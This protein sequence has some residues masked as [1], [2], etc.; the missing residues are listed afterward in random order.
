MSRGRVFGRVALGVLVAALI[1]SFLSPTFG[2]NVESIPTLLGFFLGLAVTLVVFE[3][4]GLVLR[5][6]STGEWGRLKVLPWTLLVAALFVLV[7]RLANLQPGYLYGLVLGTDYEREPRPGDEARE[8]IAGMVAT[9]LL[10]IGAW[11]V[12]DGVRAGAFAAG[13]AVSTIA[14]TATAAI[15]VNGLEAAAFG[16]LPL[17]FMPGRA[18]YEWNRRAWAVLFAASVFTFVQLLIGPTSG[19]L[20]DL[21]LQGW[22]AAIGVFAAFGAFSIGF[23]AWFRFRPAPAAAAPGT[24][25]AE[26]S[27]ATAGPAVA[28]A[29][30]PVATADAAPAEP[31]VARAEPAAAD[32]GTPPAEPEA[33]PASA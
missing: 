17:R 32:P 21:D 8:T 1:S 25:T 5:H 18:V 28:M 20:V 19:Y 3:V 22:L 16:M 30:P 31:S 23:W 33:A 13:D 24:S 6:R 27:V 10:A 12:L 29:E 7:S 4:P 26:P 9:L 15:V 14:S 2:P 11:V